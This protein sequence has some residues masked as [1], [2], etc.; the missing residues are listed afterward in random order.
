[1]E[2]QN[3]LNF[4]LWLLFSRTHQLMHKTRQ[5]EFEK[6]GIW[7]RCAAVLEMTA[8]LKDG[9]TQA[10]LVNETYF[11]RNTISE[12]LSRMEKKGAIKR[13]RDL[14]RK[15]AIRIEMTEEGKKIYQNTLNRES[16]NSVFSVLTEEEKL[17]MW[18]LLTKV[19]EK[20]ISDLDLN[21]ATLFPPSNPTEY[22]NNK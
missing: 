2:I 15:N 19:R 17:E 10:A 9:A 20:L 22:V 14:G 13:I 12:Q 1:M 3:T 8:R 7:G 16:I 6:Y 18:R 21:N 4:G 11:E 5:K